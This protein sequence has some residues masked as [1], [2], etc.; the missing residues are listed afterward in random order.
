MLHGNERRPRVAATAQ[1]NASRCPELKGCL[2]SVLQRGEAKACFARQSVGGGTPLKGTVEVGSE[3]SVPKTAVRNRPKRYSTLAVGVCQTCG[4]ALCA[5]QTMAR[6]RCTQRFALCSHRFNKG[7]LP[8]VAIAGV[9]PVEG[10]V[11]GEAPYARS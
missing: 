4:Q 3:Y 5:P 6:M 1:G 2:G 11:E 9:P 8:H 10:T 7:A